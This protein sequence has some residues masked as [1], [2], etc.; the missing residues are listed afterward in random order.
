M[1]WHDVIH[2]DLFIRNFRVGLTV[3]KFPAVILVQVGLPGYGA[4]AV[5]GC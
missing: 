3:L 4:N 1:R 2:A 5:A